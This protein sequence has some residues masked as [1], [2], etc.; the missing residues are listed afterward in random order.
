VRGPRTSIAATNIAIAFPDLDPRARRRLLVDSFERMGQGLA[1]VAL[2]PQLDA[3]EVRRWV[4]L[5]GAEHLEQARKRSP[6]GG[7]IALTAHFGSFEFF[8]AAMGLWGI[9]LTIVH[10]E[11]HAAL[12]PLVM[13]WREAAGVEV[14]T[15]GNAARA[16]LRALRDAKVVA[17]P[18]DQDSG[19]REGIFAPFFGRPAKTR[20][21]PARLAMRTGAPVV[22]VFLFRQDGGPHH[23]V[24]F[25]PALELVPQ[26]EGDEAEAVAE[27][28]RRMNAAIEAAVREAPDHWAWVHRR[29][30][31]RPE[32]TP[33]PYRPARPGSPELPKSPKR[34][35]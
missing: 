26:G 23:V 24:R 5:E 29:W 4:S 32:G 33:H 2:L 31:T 27:N 18:L 3:D 20:D 21:A 28:V 13:G 10:R 9:P 30:K 12:Q 1:E 15:R 22:P 11:Q 14:L 25:E 8:A 7:A 35:G 19:K 34:L 16:V 17:M 6:G